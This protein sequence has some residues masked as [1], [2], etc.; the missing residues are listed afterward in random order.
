MFDL[1]LAR[2][3]DGAPRGAGFNA[4]ASSIDERERRA[5]VRVACVAGLSVVSAALLLF[6]DDGSVPWFD[7]SSEL[8][9]AAQRCD[10]ITNGRQQHACQRE[11]LQA[12]A[13]LASSP[14]ALVR[15]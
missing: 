13:R 7:A 1:T 3:T 4:V 10:A 2:P 6:V 12:A 15:H 8:A 9:I 14:T 11:P 5:I